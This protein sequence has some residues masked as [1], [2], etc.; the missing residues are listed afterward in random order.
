MSKGGGQSPSGD[1]LM[2][3]IPGNYANAKAIAAQPF[4]G[5]TGQLA[6]NVAPQI[7]QA[8]QI[9]GN[10][11]AYQPQQVAAP[12]AAAP[13]MNAASSG[14]YGLPPP[15]PA[16]S[17]QGLVMGG[18]ARQR[19]DRTQ[20]VPAAAPAQQGP[21]VGAMQGLQGLDSYMNPYMDKVADRTLAG[22]D[23]FRQMSLNDNASQANM[24]GAWG[25][26]RLGVENGLTNEAF[27]KQ[28]ADSLASLYAG[29][30]DTGAGLLMGD[31]SNLLQ[32]QQFNAGLQQQAGLA[33]QNAGLQTNLANAQMGLT[34]Q[35]ANQNA[36]MQGAGMNLNAAQTLGGL[37]GLQF[38][39]ESAA[40]Q[41]AYQEFLRQVSDPYQKQAL[42]NSSLSLVPYQYNEPQRP[43]AQALPSILQGAA[44]GAGMG[45]MMG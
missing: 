42:L 12:T 4:R 43:W 30:F 45:M 17:A 40:T 9:A 26:D 20:P 24:A 33:N 29:G 18:G 16:P 1:Y 44:Q 10:V 35:L 14:V 15:M 31:K 6:P 36:G 21:A 34:G 27:A 19:R 7:G 8:T 28:A 2:S 5:Y 39:Q 13:R 22:L 38:G 37:G 23:R 32:N 11:G 25:N 3:Q 41:A